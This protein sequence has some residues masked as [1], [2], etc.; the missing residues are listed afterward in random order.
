MARSE[1]GMSLGDW[2]GRVKFVRAT[3]ALCTRKADQPHRRGA[4]LFRRQR[5]CRNV[6]AARAVHARSVS[7]AASGRVKARI[8]GCRFPPRRSSE[9]ERQAHRPAGALH[10]T[11]P[12]RLRHLPDRGQGLARDMRVRWALEELAVAYDVQL[13]S[14]AG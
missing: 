13:L 12:H 14:F 9:Q 8:E 4:W 11:D 10:A 2:R 3:E 7:G 1:L 6:Q 5:V